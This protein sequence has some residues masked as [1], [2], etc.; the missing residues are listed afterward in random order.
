MSSAASRT[1]QSWCASV[2]EGRPLER[3]FAG[4]LSAGA[5][6]AWLEDC[7]ELTFCR[8]RR[9][10]QLMETSHDE[11]NFRKCTRGNP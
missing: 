8:R 9:I 3:Y 4:N 11:R 7:Q 10:A 6:Y 5:L 2:Q 1:T